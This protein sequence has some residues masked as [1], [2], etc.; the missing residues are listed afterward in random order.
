MHEYLSLNYA[1]GLFEC[2][3]NKSTIFRNGNNDDVEPIGA[4]NYCR[5]PTD[6]NSPWCF[7][8]DPEVR[9]EECNVTRCESGQYNICIVM[10]QG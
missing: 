5:N 6:H 3:N 1:P 10:Y 9:W 4:K 8:T 7:T 2:E